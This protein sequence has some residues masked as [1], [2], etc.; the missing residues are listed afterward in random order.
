MNRNWL[1]YVLTFSLALNGATATA[2]LLFWV[3][4]HSLAAASVGHKP[5]GSF[6]REDLKLPSEK[7]NSILRLVD[8]SKQEVADLRAQL[9]S[10]RAELMKLIATVPVNR[11]VVATKMDEIGRTRSKLRSTAVDTVITIAESLPPESQDKFR[12]YLQARGRASYVV[13]PPNAAEECS[14]RK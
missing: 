8:K 14:I 13:S 3:R 11:D 2:F 12:E 4:N 7:T 5:I 10:K 9:D 6:L 1:I